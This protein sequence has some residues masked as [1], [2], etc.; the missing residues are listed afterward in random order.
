MTAAA[1]ACPVCGRP[2]DALRARA[3]GVRGGKV[4][5]YCSVDCQ[6]MAETPAGGVPV[7]AASIPR[8]VA[9]LDSG[10]II[11]IIR[12]KSEPVPARDPTPI[13][14]KKPK[15]ADTDTR[16]LQPPPD[17]DDSDLGPPEEEAPSERRSPVVMILIVV[18]LAAIAAAVAFTL[19]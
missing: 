6:R 15:R 14:T 8:T 16:S 4:V 2:V 12:E 18:V 17:Y 3:V 7:P 9:D 13:P 1:S 19:K 10:P 5:A 11:E